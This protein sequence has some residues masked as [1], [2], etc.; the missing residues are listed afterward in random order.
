MNSYIAFSGGVESTAMALMFS[1]KSQPI[2]TD[3]GWE[4]RELYDWIAKVEEKI[5]VDV[6][7][8]KR[9]GETLPEYI[10]RAKFYPSGMARFCTRM[11]KIEPMDDF[12]KD[13]VPCEILIGLN[14]DEQNRTGNH[15]LMDGVSY[16]YPLIELGLT[17]Q[18]CIDVLRE[19]ELLPN[20][21]AY[22]RRGGCVG[23]FWKSRKEYALMAKQ[24]P[25][26][27]DEV[28]AIEEEIQDER[29]SHYAV[30][31]GIPNMRQFVDKCRSIPHT[32]L[33][34]FDD[35]DDGVPTSCGVF[36]RR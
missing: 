18:N 33:P 25:D 28:A 35:S 26:E 10:K 24:S 34:L 13:K 15:G 23:C 31:D 7:R 8:I 32:Q 21:P 6:L 11:F 4:H 12:L 2:F 22:M 3:T 30:R 19:H 20:F 14:V 29:G 5:G 1:K 9:D 16:R 36:C 17:R 27:A